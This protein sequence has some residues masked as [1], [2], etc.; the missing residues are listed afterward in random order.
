MPVTVTNYNNYNKYF[1]VKVTA[2]VFF[3]TER[4][5]LSVAQIIY[6]RI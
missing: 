2:C 6:C 4:Y 1:T 3:S 5:V